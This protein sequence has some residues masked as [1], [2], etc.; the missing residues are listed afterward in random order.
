MPSS[1]RIRPDLR[2]PRQNSNVYLLS[3]AQ[4]KGPASSII[5]SMDPGQGRGPPGGRTPQMSSDILSELP[6]EKTQAIFKAMY[7]QGTG[8]QDEATVEPAAPAAN[9]TVQRLVPE[10][11]ARSTVQPMSRRRSAAPRQRPKTS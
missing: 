6:A 10:P 8:H 5:A 9:G 11:R 3:A 4:P 2:Q 7:Q 1:T